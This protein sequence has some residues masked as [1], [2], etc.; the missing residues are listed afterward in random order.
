MKVTK[1]YR[2]QILTFR[3]KKVKN[4]TKFKHPTSC[5]HHRGNQMLSSPVWHVPSYTL[6]MISVTLT[7]WQLLCLFKNWPPF[8]IGPRLGLSSLPYQ[9]PY[10]SIWTIAVWFSSLLLNGLFMS[11]N[12]LYVLIPIVVNSREDAPTTGSTRVTQRKW[13]TGFTKTT[14]RRE[15]EDIP[16]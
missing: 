14:W 12:N 3:K 15:E 5:P 10:S 6:L 13:T 4:T 11:V 1:M 7:L 9:Y 8:F 16:K 2:I